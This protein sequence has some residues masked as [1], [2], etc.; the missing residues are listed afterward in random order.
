MRVVKIVRLRLRSLFRSRRVEHDLAD[1]LRDHLERQIEAHVAAGMSRTAAREAAHREF[2]NVPL[3]QEH[4][5][6]TRGVTWLQDLL[7]D[8]AYGL[9]SMRRAPEHTAVAALSLAVGIGANTATFSLVNALLLR[10]LPVADP[11]DLVELGSETSSGPGNFSYPLYQRV[12]QQ[13]STFI[14][15]AAV[16]SPVIRADDDGPDQPPHGRYVSGNF[17]E[18]LGLQAARGRLLT[19]SDDRLDSANGAA[20]AVISDGLWKR[21]FG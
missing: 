13:N 17:F 11:Q 19:P 3:V 9:R 7:R 1:E 16:S 12:H 21:L 14:E 5:R 20:V 2:G 8:A 10:P 18:T 4:C 15:V 6:D